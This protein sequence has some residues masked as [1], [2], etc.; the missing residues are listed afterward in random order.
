MKNSSI[1]NTILHE[2]TTDEITV[3]LLQVHSCGQKLE[4]ENGE[5][6]P[7]KTLYELILT[8]QE[9]LQSPDIG[10][11]YNFQFDDFAK[12]IHTQYG[13]MK[14]R[15]K[16]G[17]GLQKRQAEIIIPEEEKLLCETKT[18]CVENPQ[19]LLDTLFFLVG[20]N[21]ALRGGEEH[22]QLCGGP[23]SLLRLVDED[24][25]QYTQ[26]VSKSNQGDLKHK[27]IA[28]KKVLAYTIK[29]KPERCVVAVYKLYMSHCPV[30]Y[31]GQFHLRPHVNPKG[32]VWYTKT[33]FG[34]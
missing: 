31:P 17:I 9:Y 7:H 13:A 32:K 34:P 11:E 19:K 29:D 21:F 12:L 24:T 10:K 2:R 5:K 30:P 16:Q 20:L 8:L 15:E 25:L 33:L 3:F 27:E 23:N 18:L 28:P 26:N 6:Y 14:E 4:K 22:H 1:F